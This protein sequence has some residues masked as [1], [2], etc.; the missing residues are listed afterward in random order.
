LEQVFA[1][2]DAAGHV[3][4]APDAVDLHPLR[5]RVT[6][7]NVSFAYAS[8]MEPVLRNI[9]I[10]VKPGEKTAIAGPSGAGMTTLMALLQRF[11]DPT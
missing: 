10:D 11:C 5:G 6:F 2:L 4:D 3:E 1:I 8:S 9:K 7:R